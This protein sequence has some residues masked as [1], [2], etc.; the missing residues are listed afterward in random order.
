MVNIDDSLG[1][2]KLDFS[3][4]WLL[5]ATSSPEQDRGYRNYGYDDDNAC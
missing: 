1:F 4:L 5:F 3:W 2:G